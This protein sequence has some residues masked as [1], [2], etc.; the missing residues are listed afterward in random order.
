MRPRKLLHR[1]RAGNHDNVRFGD[2]QAL[3]AA[4]GYEL[5]RVSGSHHIYVHKNLP[6]RLSFQEVRGQAKAYQV[7]QSL[8]EL[9]GYDLTVEDDR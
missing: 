5:D 3:M 6:S 2:L 4:C 1:M 9:D 7:R 8:D